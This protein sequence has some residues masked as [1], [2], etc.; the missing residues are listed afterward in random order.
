MYMDM[1]HVGVDCGFLHL[2]IGIDLD[3]FDHWLTGWL[4]G[5]KV[6]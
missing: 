3:H 1:Y 5:C 2:S 4:T 6:N